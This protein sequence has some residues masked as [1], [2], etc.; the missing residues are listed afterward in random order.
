MVIYCLPSFCFFVGDHFLTLLPIEVSAVNRF[1]QK[2]QPAIF[3]TKLSF[4]MII[5]QLFPGSC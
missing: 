2:D 5:F 1:L 4:G 3:A